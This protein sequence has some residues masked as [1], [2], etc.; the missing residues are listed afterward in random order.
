M[1]TP[2]PWR[3]FNSCDIFPDDGDVSGSKHIA[4]FAPTS[5]AISDSERQA[6][7]RLIAAAPEMLA[8]LKIV[9]QKFEAF[10]DD[11]LAVLEMMQQAIAKAEPGSDD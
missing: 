4:D 8:A 6:N 5:D 1:H 3:I 9:V 11:D 2:G 7:G 10:E